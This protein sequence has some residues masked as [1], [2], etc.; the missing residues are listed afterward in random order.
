MSNNQGWLKLEFYGGP[1]DGAWQAVPVGTAVFYLAFG[2]VIHAYQID[3]VHEGCCV[4]QIMRH[5]EIL[6]FSRW[7]A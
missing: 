4:R 3:E 2:A 1:L 7:F 6:N 5:H